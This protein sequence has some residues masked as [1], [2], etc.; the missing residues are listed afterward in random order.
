MLRCIILIYRKGNVLKYY[1][2]IN[3]AAGQGREAKTLVSR[4]VNSK[5]KDADYRIYTTNSIGDGEIK[6]RELAEALGEDEGTFFAC[7][8][9]GTVNEIANGIC[10]Y[11]NAYLGIIPIGTGNDT[12]R[13]FGKREAFLDLDRQFEAGCH[14]VDLMRYEGMID[15]RYQKRYCI[16]MFNL[17]FDCNVV[18]LAARLKEKPFIAGSAAYLAAIFGTFV[19]KKGTSLTIRENGKLIKEGEMLLCAIANGSYCGGGIYSAPQAAVDDGYFDLNIIKDMPRARFLKLFPRY[20]AG[21]H[22]EIEGVEKLLLA[23]KL[24]NLEIEP[25]GRKDFFL[26]ADGEIVLCEGVKIVM[27]E[28]KLKVLVP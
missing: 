27:C 3:P 25:Y 20:K 5:F 7:G 16:N 14:P 17:G 12:I 8:G 4:I 10:E 6:A 9:D 19:E 18:E 28:K 11:E 21:T 13:N 2:F 22:L 26:C 15:G 24:K 23:K 1:F